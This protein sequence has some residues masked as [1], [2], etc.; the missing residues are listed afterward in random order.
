MSQENVEIVRRYY[1]AINLGDMTAALA[2]VDPNVEWW[3]RW[4]QPDQS[5]VRGH[6]A[7]RAQF[8]DIYATFADFR[9]DPMEFIAGGDFVVVSVLQVGRFQ[10]S[11]ALIEQREVHVWKLNEGRVVEVREFNEKADA[12]EAVGLSEQDAHAD[13]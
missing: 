5:V 7:W 12:L 9:M 8:D 2:E 10:N 4:D 11:D 3:V 13:S 1:R 6:D